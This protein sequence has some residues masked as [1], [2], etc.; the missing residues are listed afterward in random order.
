MIRWPPL[1][2]FF[3]SS[4]CTCLLSFF[5]AGADGP[6]SPAPH[7][8]AIGRFIL[9]EFWEP[10]M[11][12]GQGNKQPTWNGRAIPSEL[13]PHRPGRFSPASQSSVP[14]SRIWTCRQSGFYEN[15]LFW[16]PCLRRTCFLHF[17]ASLLSLPSFLSFSSFPCV[18]VIAEGE[19]GE[20][21]DNKEGSTPLHTHTY[22]ALHSP[23]E[24]EEGLFHKGE[25]GRGRTERTAAKSQD[26][27]DLTARRRCQAFF[28]SLDLLFRHLLHVV[29]SL[30]PLPFVASAA[31]C[32]LSSSPFFRS[33]HSE[34]RGKLFS[35]LC[36]EIIIIITI[37]FFVA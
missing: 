6:P 7:R 3:F 4:F 31:S 2:F 1:L 13:H 21:G 26:K 22:I 34:K 35:L 25:R 15:S 37:M 17:F 19:G 18:E 36:G 16:Q 28:P 9:Q 11:P 33:I 30:L 29:S 12:K 23:K 8:T 32:F 27:H 10:E 14:L 24:E 5:V 20:T